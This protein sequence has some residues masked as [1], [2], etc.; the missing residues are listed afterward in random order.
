MSF[1]TLIAHHKKHHEENTA[2]RARIAE[3]EAELAEARRLVAALRA[4]CGL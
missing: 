4:E 2:L 3:L 1:E